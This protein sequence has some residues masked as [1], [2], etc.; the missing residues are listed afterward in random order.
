MTLHSIT[1]SPEEDKVTFNQKMQNAQP[2]Q[3]ILLQH[4]PYA[5]QVEILNADPATYTSADTLVPGKYVVPIFL[6][7]K[8]QHEPGLHLQMFF[9]LFFIL[10]MVLSFSQTLGIEQTCWRKNWLYQVQVLWV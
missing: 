2:G 4:P 9:S 10:L 8:S 7:K 1:I 5:V 6:D 3:M